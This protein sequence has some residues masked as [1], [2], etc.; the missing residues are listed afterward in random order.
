MNCK[1]FD[2]SPNGEYSVPLTSAERAFRPQ[3]VRSNP[4][5]RSLPASPHW[6]QECSRLGIHAP[7]ISRNKVTH[8]DGCSRRDSAGR[9]GHGNCDPGIIGAILREFARSE[10]FERGI[11]GL[12]LSH[13]RGRA[14][15]EGRSIAVHPDAVLSVRRAAA[16]MRS[17]ERPG[18]TAHLSSRS[19]AGIAG[20][21]TK[22]APYCTRYPWQAGRRYDGNVQPPSTLPLN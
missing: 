3:P 21:K 22:Y 20:G 14:R 5:R 10:L 15:L 13:F 12:T 4:A 2:I 8:C 19:D 1:D 9:R 6:V 16:S 17:G 11:A 18:S 7:P